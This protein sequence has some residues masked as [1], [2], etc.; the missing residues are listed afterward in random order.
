L[1][2]QPGSPP[3]PAP[4]PEPLVIPPVQAGDRDLGAWL[5]I[6]VSP[7]SYALFGG[8]TWALT[9]DLDEDAVLLRVSGALG[10]YDQELLSGSDSDVSFQNVNVLIG[11][12]HNFENGRV[13][14]FVGPD[15][16]HNGEGASPEVRGSS[17]GVRFVG[18]AA[19]AVSPDFQLSAWGTYSTIENQYFVQGRALYRASEG[20]RI[21]P[22]IALAGGDT[23]H[24]N[25]AGGHA[26][27]GLPFGEL[28]VSVGHTWGADSN[29]DEGLY[30]N[31]ILSFVF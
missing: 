31:A 24:Q 10:E 9:G 12:Q 23:W 22:E 16:T 26:A 30:A 1:A 7:N 6:D 25:R 2:A 8:G 15:Y 28:G 3:V 17:W 11:Y 5:G 21:G 27:V 14:A 13:G 4:A 20:F 19:A 18:E 29:I